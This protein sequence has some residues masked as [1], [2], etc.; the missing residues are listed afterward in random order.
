M[1]IAK[2]KQGNVVFEGR[3]NTPKWKDLKSEVVNL[4]MVWRGVEY[5]L[6]SDGTDFQTATT[7]SCSINGGNAVIE[8]RWISCKVGNVIIRLRFYEKAMKV[9]VE[10]ETA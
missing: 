2:T 4:G 1:W 5:W 7:A 8:S 3:S 9:V 10:T 6:P